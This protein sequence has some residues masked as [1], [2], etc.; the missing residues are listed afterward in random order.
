[1]LQLKEYTIGDE[2]KILDLFKLVFKKEMSLDYWNW[3]FKRNPIGKVMIQ[4]M[5]DEQKLI[6]HYAVCPIVLKYKEMEITTALSMTTMTHPDYN[7]KG[8]FSTL[9]IELYKKENQ[10]NNLQSVWGFPNVNS[11]YGFIKNLNWK[12]V[13]QIPTLSKNI[14]QLDIPEISDYFTL[15]QVFKKTSDAVL[16]NYNNGY[17]CQVK[18]DSFYLNWRYVENPSNSYDIFTNQTETE[19]FV[20]KVFKSFSDQET[21]EIDVL[22]CLILAN[23]QSVKELISKILHHYKNYNLAK[24]NIWMPHNHPLHIL[25]ERSNFLLSE[26]V[27]FFGVNVMAED[28]E[29]MLDSRQWYFSMGDSD[30]Y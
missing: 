4:L 7:G 24:I 18:R 25:F 27:T 3:R 14:N 6:G 16:L 13:C 23:M 1:M 2:T 20:T 22:E 5:Y 12:D 30:I 28:R 21:Y 11:H 9:A 29:E 19:F 10:I 15:I 17:A 26:P 8:V